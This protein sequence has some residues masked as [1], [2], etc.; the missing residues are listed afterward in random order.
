MHDPPTRRVIDP[1]F[2]TSLLY[3]NFSFKIHSLV[4][5]DKI[6]AG[7]NITSTDPIIH[8]SHQK[9]IQLKGEKIHF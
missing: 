6:N 9:L 7:T 8:A 4:V 5:H 3:S 1:D 2:D